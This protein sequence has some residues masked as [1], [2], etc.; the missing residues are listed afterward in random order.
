MTEPSHTKSSFK[1]WL[2]KFVGIIISI[3]C[4]WYVFRDTNF[5]ELKQEIAKLNWYYVLLGVMS[6]S[7]DY[8]IRAKR[9][10]LMLQSTGAKVKTADCIPAFL[11]S[12]ALNNVLPLRAGDVVRALVFPAAIGVDRVTATASLVLE[13]LVDLLTLLIC[14]GIGLSL[15]S[16]TQAHNF[17]GNSVLTLAITGGAVLFFIMFFSPVIVKWLPT[18]QTYL[19]KKEYPR[20]ANVI[21]VVSDLL[22]HLKTMAHPYTLLILFL[23]SMCAWVGEAGLFWA[24]MKG[25]SIDVTLSAALVVMAIATLSTLLPSSPGY[26]GTF[27]LAVKSAIILLGGSASQATSF[28]IVAHLGIWL[29]TTIAGGIALICKPSLFEKNKTH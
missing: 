7:V 25:L 22:G 19:L 26:A 8:G 9:W 20:L 4:L 23:L 12:I 2:K 16:I 3:V 21:P 1:K 24:L 29:P 27:D 15:T 10:A 11:G 6:L 5:A 13:R 17:L 28:A 14:L 18:L